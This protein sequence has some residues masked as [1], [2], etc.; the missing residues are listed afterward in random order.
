MIFQRELASKGLKIERGNDE[1]TVVCD[2]VVVGSG[3]GGGTMAALLSEAGKT[4]IYP[5][6][7]HFPAN[8]SHKLWSIQ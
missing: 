3:A 2:A 6:F 4:K 8:E 1:I 7:G 5:S